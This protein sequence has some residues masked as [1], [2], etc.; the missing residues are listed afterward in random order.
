VTTGTSGTNPTTGVLQLHVNSYRNWDGVDGKFE[1]YAGG[2][3]VKWNDYSLIARSSVCT[4]RY[5]RLKGYR[6][7]NNALLVYDHP[8]SVAGSATSS[9]VTNT[10]RTKAL[11][12][13]L[14]K[15]KG[16]EFNL[17]VELGQLNQTTD[18]L[19]GNLRKLGRAALA[20]RRGDFSTAARQL[21]ARPRGTRLKPS[22]ITGRWLE[23]QYG[24]LPLMGSSFE[25]AK[26]F[27]AISQGPRTKVFVASVTEGT[28]LINLSQSPTSYSAVMQGKKF[29][30]LQ[31]EMYEEMSVARQLGMV[32]PFSIAWELTPWSFVIDWFYP[33][34]DYL[35]NLNQIPTLK[36]R[37]MVTDGYKFLRQS[38]AW[39]WLKSDYTL[40]TV[41]CH[42]VTAE[43][44]PTLVKGSTVWTRSALA[45]PPKVPFPS[46]NPSKIAI[47]QK[48]FWIAVS[49][50][51]Q[52][53]LK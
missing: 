23:L 22:D 50:A 46:F 3:R 12:K 10:S 16:H 39:E 25:A 49:L 44:F 36:G 45:S 52:R 5:I 20:L 14:G 29:Y 48:R 53:F 32:D 28:G 34:G 15:I 2:Q 24:W 33:F 9:T 27:E 30:R 4:Q 31:Y 26:A 19:A 42:G 11:Q 8:I 17:G 1:P 51:H 37:W 40:G 47:S 13:I 35:S 6:N 18:L 41:A 38:P 43:Y 7:T 21:G